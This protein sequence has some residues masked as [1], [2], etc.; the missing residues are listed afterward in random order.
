MTPQARFRRIGWFALLGVCTL[1]YGLL[2]LQVWSVSSEVK[3]AERQ[4]VA[5]EQHKMLLETE[6]L[7]RSSQAQLAAW[8]RVDFGY[9]APRADQFIGSE[10]QLASFGAA[11]EQNREEALRLASFSAD[12]EVAPFPRLVSPITGEPL[13]EDLVR[14]A[15][16]NG[17]GD[18]QASVIA[19]VAQGAA[20][21][22]LNAPARAGATVRV[23]LGG[24]GQ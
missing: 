1:F 7:T 10:R 21:V 12:E 4:I 20:R 23:M 9:T 3:R 6:F 14:P 19:A 18:G 16:A 22:P 13:D 17:G 5:L 11:G 24:V 2:H 15:A 8:N